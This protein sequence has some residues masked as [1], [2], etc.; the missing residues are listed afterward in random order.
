M[1]LLPQG[2]VGDRQESSVALV[3]GRGG[4]SS[5]FKLQKQN[6]RKHEAGEPADRY[7][8]WWH[9]W[10]LLEVWSRR[11]PTMSPPAG[12]MTRS[13]WLPGDSVGQKDVE[14]IGSVVSLWCSTKIN[15][16]PHGMMGNTWRSPDQTADWLIGSRRFLETVFFNCK[17]TLDSEVI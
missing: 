5:V 4:S 12:R 10:H 3:T 13:D 1:N 7:S 11:P 14:T 8:T 16:S 2:L 6:D 17:D 9:H 15:I